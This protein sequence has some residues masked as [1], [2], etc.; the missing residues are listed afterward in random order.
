[1]SNRK[2]QNSLLFITTLG[3]YLGLVLVGAAP[4]LG[5]AA[6]TRNFEISDEIEYKD[7]LDKKPDEEASLA[8]FTT[9]FEQL[10]RAAAD[11]SAV[12]EGLSDDLLSFNYFVS[13]KPTGAQ[14][15]V[16]PAE[17]NNR[18]SVNLGNFSKP[19]QLLHDGFLPH[20]ADWHEK[21]FVQFELGA[22]DI[23]FRVTLREPGPAEAD[24]A[25]DAYSKA[26]Y[27]RLAL[28]TAAARLSILRSVQVTAEGDRVI[29]VT[30]LPRAALDPPPATD[31]K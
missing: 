19:L 29:I 2:G 5:H 6:T 25:V 24:S 3:V 17:F 15:H 12:N 30:R 10:V 9:C 4:V 11:W 7:D 18:R 13:V 8:G 21:L 1:M 23:S 31:A 22:E 26:L 14:R 27:R 20:E 28:E 16:S